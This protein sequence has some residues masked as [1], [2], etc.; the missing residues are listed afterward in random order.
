VTLATGAS[1]TVTFSLGADE[2]GFWTNDPAGEFV[3]E[4]G[5]FVVTLTDA[6]TS[7]HLPLRLT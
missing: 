7:L 5:D 6:T 1:R 4:P 3:V 2:L